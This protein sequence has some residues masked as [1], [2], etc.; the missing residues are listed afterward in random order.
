MSRPAIK[1]MIRSAITNR[2]EMKYYTF[3][4]ASAVTSSATGTVFNLTRDLIEGDNIEQRTGRKIQQ[5]WSS[6]R[7][8]AILPAAAV[9]GTIRFIWVTDN[10]NTGTLPS[11]TEILDSATVT[12]HLAL[13]AVVPP[14]FTV[15]A[16]HTYSMVVGGMNQHI[17]PILVDKKK[18]DVFYNGS[19]A[20]NTANGHGAQ[21]LLAIT[22]LALNQPIFTA[23]Y[24]L[25]Y[26]DI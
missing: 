24:A 10:Y 19:T 15:V 25:K 7:L 11:V 6:L 26:L 20:V 23:D 1:Q 12:S 2:A 22:D 18:N 21:F 8:S 14:R 13:S 17:S 9:A 4:P 16:D 3:T 5:M